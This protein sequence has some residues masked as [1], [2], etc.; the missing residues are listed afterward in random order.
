[1]RA[2]RRTSSR[3]SRAVSCASS[4]RSRSG[5]RHVARGAAELQDDAGQRLPDAVVELLRDAQPLALLRGER[6]GDAVAALGLEALEHLVE[7]RG[8]LGGIGVAS[9][10]V[11]PMA[12]LERVDLAR[13]RGQLAQRRERPA[14]QQEVDG[15]HQHEAA[16]EDRQLADGDVLG[17]GREHERRDRARGGEHGGIADRE[18]PEERRTAGGCEHGPQCD[19]LDSGSTGT[20]TEACSRGSGREH[21][22]SETVGDAGGPYVHVAR[23]SMP[24]AMGAAHRG[25]PVDE[26]GGSPLR[27]V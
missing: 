22:A 24:V 4:T 7:R 16:G 17:L 11:E 1:M 25:N 13:E 8:Q 20:P 9:A 5:S 3:L 14:Q 18:P 10:D 15:E 21:A 23:R 19:G 12:G 6:A 2:I 27:S 26:S